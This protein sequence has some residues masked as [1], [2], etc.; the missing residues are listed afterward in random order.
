MLKKKSSRCQGHWDERIQGT[1]RTK[2]DN[3]STWPLKLSRIIC[4]PEPQF[5]LSIQ[6]YRPRW[7][8]G[9][10]S[11]CQCR[12][13][14]RHRFNTWVGK[15]PWRRKWQLTPVFL[16]EECHGQR[17]LVGYKEGL[18]GVTNTR[19]Q[20]STHEDQDTQAWTIIPHCTAFI[21]ANTLSTLLAQ[22]LAFRQNTVTEDPGIGSSKLGDSM[23]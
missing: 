14:K 16:P 3:S 9:K 23:V 4:F 13:L 5:Y 7:H 11:V 8:S 20:L 22:F 2:L 1:M 18:H 12:R 19:T 17:S 15:I 21:S 6:W 10:E